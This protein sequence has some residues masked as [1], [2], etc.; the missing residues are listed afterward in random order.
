MLFENIMPA[1][2]LMEF[3]L[4]LVVA[5]DNISVFI[6]SA[7]TFYFIAFIFQKA[8]DFINYNIKPFMYDFGIKDSL[9]KFF[10]PIINSNDFFKISIENPSFY[11]ELIEIAISYNNYYLI[12]KLS[13]IKNDGNKN[14][15]DMVFEIKY[16]G[17]NHID[18]RKFLLKKDRIYSY[19][20]DNNLHQ[21]KSEYEMQGNKKSYLQER[22]LSFI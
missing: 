8:L 14:L 3:F 9:Y 17:S 2:F 5:I 20:T 19:M 12:N 13:N 22:G 21:F 7:Y 10:E 11:L 15:L 4:V 1:L 16:E 6:I 18:V